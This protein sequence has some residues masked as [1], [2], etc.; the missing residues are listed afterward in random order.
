MKENLERFLNDTER[1]IT[2]EGALGEEEDSVVKITVTDLRSPHG[3]LS[4]DAQREIFAVMTFEGILRMAP[5]KIEPNNQ[6]TVPHLE[7]GILPPRCFVIEL[8]SLIPGGGLLPLL[9]FSSPSKG[10]TW[11]WHMNPSPW[12]G[13]S[14]GSLLMA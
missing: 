9:F 1:I 3:R 6:V 12:G 11:I 2:E 7:E 14:S 4:R 10:V 13:S 5:V 8:E